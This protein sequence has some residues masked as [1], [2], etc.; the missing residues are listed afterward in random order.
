M[1]FPY[2][3]GRQYEL[4]ALRELA[5]ERLLGSRVIPVVEPVKI[6]STFTNMVQMFIDNHLPIALV[7]NPADGEASSRAAAGMAFGAAAGMVVLPVVG[8]IVGAALGAAVGAAIDSAED[9]TVDRVLASISGS[10]TVIPSVIIGKDTAGT[11]KTL[12]SKG[13]S[14]S[15]VLTILTNRD[16]LGIYQVFFD[17]APPKFAML[18]DDRRISRTVRA[19]K[20]IFEDRIK[21]QGKDADFKKQDDEFYSDDH[22][23]FREEG[24]AGFS[25][26]SVIGEDNAE[27]GSD[28]NDIAIHIV[29]F[30]SGGALR[31]K[32]FTSDSDSDKK[33]AAGQYYEAVTKLKRWYGDGK[34]GQCTT[35]LATFLTHAENGYYPGMLIVKK[36]SI[37]HHL[38]LVGKYLDGVLGGGIGGVLGGGIGGG[39]GGGIGGGIGGG[40]G[41][42]LST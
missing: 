32:H 13:I 15:D 35:A 10:G 42:G 17:D 24:F 29:Y 21:K 36:L 34:S 18:P 20:I 11:V 28:P 23:Y 7:V 38:E 22:L 1:Y 26:Y 27:N 5:M 12:T 31:V 14:K 9:A 3:K 39:A 30:A 8:A 19:S 33:D 6:T 40:V 16:S 4:F 2:I 41:G 37:M 25:D